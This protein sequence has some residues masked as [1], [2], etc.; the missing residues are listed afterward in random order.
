MMKFLLMFVVPLMT[1]A[2]DPEPVAAAQP[3]PAVTGVQ[4]VM[5]TNAP[6]VVTG[7][8]AST[9]AVVNQQSIPQ[10]PNTPVVATGQDATDV[11]SITNVTAPTVQQPLPVQPPQQIL[12]VPIV[13]QAVPAVQPAGI[14]VK[15]D[16][17]STAPANL[18]NT[19]T[20]PSVVPAV[21]SPSV[22]TTVP[23]PAVA[24]TQ[25]RTNVPTVV[26]ASPPEVTSSHSPAESSSNLLSQL[27]RAT[28][29]DRGGSIATGPQVETSSVKPAADLREAEGQLNREGTTP[30]GRAD[31]RNVTL[32]GML[33]GNI[34]TDGLPIGTNV[35]ASS[36][37]DITTSRILLGIGNEMSLIV[38]E[39]L[40]KL[41]ELKVLEDKK[42]V[43]NTQ[44][45][46]SLRES[47][48]TEYQKFIQE[49][50]EI[51]NSDENTKMDGIQSSDIAQTLRYKYDASVKNIMANVM[52]I[53][54]TKGKYDGAILAYNYIKDKVQS[55]KNGIK[56]P[57]SEYLKLIRDIDFSADNIIDP[58]INNEEKVGIQLKD[59]KSKIFGLLSNNTNN[60]ITYDL[61]KKIIEHFN[62]LQEEHSIANSLI[63]GA[64]KFSNK[65]EHLTNKLKISISKYVAT[66][67]ESNTIKFIH[68]ASNA[69][70]KTNNTQIIMNTTNDSNAVK[71]TS[72]VQ[73]MSVPL[74]ESSSNLLS[75]MGR[76]TPRDRGG[77]EGSDGMKSS[78]GPQVE[79]A[80][81]LREA[82]G[83]VNKE[84]DGRN[85]TSGGE[86]DGRNVTSGG[87][88]SSLEDNTWNYGGINTENTKAKGNLKGK[89]EGELKL[90]D[91]EDEEEAVKD[92]F[93]HIKI[94]ATLLLSL[95]LV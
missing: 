36:E 86:A 21:G 57:S 75:Q 34:I 78:T 41:E 50:T 79:P 60:N 65:L 35:S 8:P 12:Q 29:G 70:E 30:S 13:Q 84:A 18:E 80:A 55:I 25:D 69:L 5:P 90:V 91:D 43:G 4:Q 94:I 16:N 76:A 31:G 89:E 85:V 46:E 49:I 54:N 19:T 14:E 52:K 59:A 72:D 27:G 11:R 63:N 93:N 56:N 15:K 67:D 32:G 45:L 53:L 83:E 39:I 73:S 82:E 77:N 74:A 58:M 2:V 1:L 68:Q 37:G 64:K 81:D 95:T 92:G 51:E 23:L 71:S 17:T 40:V 38:D 62:S 33:D 87:K 66:A 7:Q 48:I 28:P 44:K 6:V 3:Q 10:A 24:T 42:L 22:T 88:T 26:E 20:V 47:I 61:K 9:P